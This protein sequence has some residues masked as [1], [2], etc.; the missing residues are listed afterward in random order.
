VIPDQSLVDR[1]YEASV[2][3]ERWPGVLQSLADQVGSAGATI[4]SRS[5]HSYDL[6]VSPS[7]VDD[8]SAFID[9]GWDTNTEY[10]APL[11]A[12][13]WPGFRTE[14]DYRTAEEIAALPVHARFLEP[15]GFVAGT[16]TVI[17]GAG[18][19]AV[20]FALEGFSS[21][22]AARG[23][24][25]F[26]DPLRPHLARAVS[27]T[28]LHKDRSQLV[29]DS[30]ALANVSAAV[31]GFNNH[32]RAVNAPFIGRMGDRMIETLSGL[33]F[34]DTLLMQQVTLALHR[35]RNARGGVQ[36]VPVRNDDPN[37]AMAIHLLPITGAARDACGSDGVLLII[38][39]PA[40]VSVPSSDL[41]RLL[42]DLTPA[43][44]R[45]SRHLIEG[46]TIASA[47]QI[48]GVG[49]ATVRAHLK[50]IFARTGVNRQSDLVR[51]LG[52]LGSPA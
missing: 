9:E 14:T 18:N 40:N 4:V 24:I 19:F 8:A 41:L 50:A 27:L 44:A 1:I 29:V 21:H 37:D 38:A 49:H 13:L 17:Q 51:L 5:Q 39:E 45:I 22:A 42:F 33:R 10:T 23:A 43:E 47:A 15:R 12:E 11:F 7:M 36:S 30:L 48:F 34:T 28:A 46:G 16:A 35:H 25:G 26:L 32:L 3:T 6:I 52:T 2:L 20:H 31:I